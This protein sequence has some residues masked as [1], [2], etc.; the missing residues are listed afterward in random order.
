MKM[1]FVKSCLMLTVTGLLASSFAIAQEKAQTLDQLLDMVKKSQ[2]SESAE[3]KQREAEFARD[4]A[5]QAN[6]LAQAKATRQA[7]EA[8]SVALE[9]K[10]QEQ[11]I[12][13]AAK[14]VQ[15]NERLGS[16]KELF[17]H[18][19]STAGDLRA[20]LE[21]SIVSAQFP[22]R[23]EFLDTLIEKM[24]SNT[25]LPDIEEIERLWFEVQRE[26]VEGGR[27]VKFTANVIKP[28]G[29]Q[30]SQE[31]VRVGTYNLVSNGA[32]LTYSG[33]KIQELARQ[34]SAHV[35]TA[36]ALQTATGG[37]VDFG[38]DP[39]GPAGGQLLTALIDTPTLVERW[40]QGGSVGYVITAVGVFGVLL[41]LYRILVLLGVSGKV[42]A[43]LK[44]D[45]PNLNNPLGRVLKV[46]EENK[47]VDTETLELKLEEAVLKERPS[48]ESGLAVLKII[49]AVAP[50]LG[51]LGTVTGMI[52]T[53]QAITIFGAGDPKN[54]AGGISSALVTTVQGLVVAIPVVLIHTLVNGR[55]KA[56]I[57][58]LD[59]QTTGIIAEN[60]ERK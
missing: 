35:A 38:V 14:K 58:V 34:P 9:K 42:R 48:I 23:G 28:S 11:D 27:V 13:V 1:K 47:N 40:H 50:L 39:T 3:H 57:Q 20:T 33:G 26:M 41:G 43:Q 52:E 32:Y 54:M 7:E 36:A 2:I 44:S 6:L 5:N 56:V 8:R 19:T 10:Y 12:L 29:E 22:N 46:A 16:M 55:A 51:L 15:L 53:F 17:G 31:V 37:V 25:Q 49:A 30:S 18:L 24:N 60:S 4:K 45:K 59:E 21:G